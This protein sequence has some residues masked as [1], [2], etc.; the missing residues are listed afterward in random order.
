M[1]EISDDMIRACM[2]HRQAE[3]ITVRKERLNVEADGGTRMEPAIT[4]PTSNA[5]INRELQILKRAYSLN[6]QKL[7]GAPPS[8]PKLRESAL[9]SGF[10]ERAQFE[11]VQANLPEALRGLV[12]FAYITGWRV[13][14]EV[15]TLEWRQVDFAAGTVCLDPGRPKNGQGRLFPMT[16]ELRELLEEQDRARKATGQIVPW[17]F[18]RLVAKGRRGEKHPSQSPPLRRH[19]A[20][21][22]GSL[23]AL[24]GYLTTSGARLCATSCGQECRSA[25]RCR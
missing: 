18:F 17:V 16:T 6:R 12:A 19:G 24:A 8:M 3:Q 5:E 15:Q 2:A 10:F 23:V 14:S 22:A 9:R 7:L 11:S 4:K 25:L 1:S 21:P 20:T 13:P